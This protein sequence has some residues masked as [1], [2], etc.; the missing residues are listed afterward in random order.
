MHYIVEAG[1]SAVAYTDRPHAYACAGRRATK[2]TM[3]VAEWH[4]QSHAPH[5]R[6]RRV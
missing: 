4:S 6:R 2:F 3:V 5:S 1:G